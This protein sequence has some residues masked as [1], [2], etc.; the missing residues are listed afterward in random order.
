MIHMSQPEIQ[1]VNAIKMELE[2]FAKSIVEDVP[3]KVSLQDGIKAL[4][5]AHQ[6]ITE[7]EKRALKNYE[8]RV[9]N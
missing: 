3:T 4:S 9:R 7:I 6:V 2:T 5:I 1:P 8:L